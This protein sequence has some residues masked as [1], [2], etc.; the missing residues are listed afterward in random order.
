MP[1]GEAPHT[2]FCPPPSQSPRMAVLEL[3]H[4]RQHGQVLLTTQLPVVATRVPRVER[5][6]PDHVEGL[7]T[8][9][10]PSV[11]QAGLGWAG[12]LVW[13]R[14][15]PTSGG[16]E[17]LLNFIIWYMYSVGEEVSPP[18]AQRHGPHHRLTIPAAIL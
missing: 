5:V 7:G 17:N 15:L 1:C 8:E 9:K 12:R 2:P 3:L 14:P 18:G 11:L 10:P 6:E 4:P 13:P 16:R